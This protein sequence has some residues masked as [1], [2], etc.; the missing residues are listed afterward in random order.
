MGDINLRVLQRLYAINI[1]W[2]A[3]KTQAMRFFVAP[4]S[5]YNFCCIQIASEKA[6]I[7]KKVN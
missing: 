2:I 7:A 3:H 4:K 1:V 6:P 5:H